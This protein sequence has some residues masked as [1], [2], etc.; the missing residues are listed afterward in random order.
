[1]ISKEIGN[2][3]LE[4]GNL[5][6]GR[7]GFTII[8]LL[9]VMVI[10]AILAGLSIFAMGGARES[11]RDARRKA[12]LEQIRSGLELYKADCNVYP[13]S[14]GTSLTGDGSTPSCLAANT[15]IQDVP[16]DP[17]S[18]AAY[19]YNQLTTVTYTL[20]SHLEDP[21]SSPDITNC[22]ACDPTPCAYKVI[23]P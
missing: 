3:K 11:A 5:R 8:E 21:P 9:I 14:L 22:N 16:T 17:T 6:Q 13:A 15:Y 1:M 20:C 7:A 12:D 18:D 19:A 23:N 10:I 4:I 2:W